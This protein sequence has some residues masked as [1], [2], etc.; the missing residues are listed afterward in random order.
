M[1]SEYYSLEKAAEVLKLP[2]AEVNRLRERSQLRAFRDGSSWK[3]K[4][5]DVDNF[6]AETIKARSKQQSS[7]SDFDL[8]GA[9][10][11]DET[12]TLLADSASFD[13]LMEGGL[14]IDD[15]MV[16]AD[17]PK[18]KT[19]SDDLTLADEAGAEVD[20]MLGDEV[21][22]DGTGSSPK[23]SLAKDS[24]LSLLEADV[25]LEPVA[26]GGSDGGIDD[27][28]DI[29]ALVDAEGAEKTSTIA[30][31]V[32]DDFQL[33]PGADMHPDDSESSSQVIALEED[34][35]FGAPVGMS[36]G[37]AFTPFGSPE[38]MA[39]APQPGPFGAG[40]YGSQMTPAF[41]TPTSS[42]PTYG[43][44][45]IVMLL[46]CAFALVVCGCMS[47]DLIIHI[48]SWKEPF[49]INSTIMNL[50]AGPLK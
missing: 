3:F 1:S 7:D 50:V 16:V 37:P 31:P 6:L 46:I 23:L 45:S 8:L 5:A 10:E 36:P 32:E 29:L 9:G 24:G 25:E 2:P 17:T 27:D 28:D 20:L 26:T 11:E 19:S 44:G 4:K 40:E 42:E 41:V 30:I 34:N 22:L 12:P 18:K 15:A 33:M 48:W 13:V 21:V 43:T 47:F 49:V 35:M 39:V 14:T 38:P